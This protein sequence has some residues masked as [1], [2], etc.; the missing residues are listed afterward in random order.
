MLIFKPTLC[1]LLFAMMLTR[2]GKAQ[3]TFDCY[4]CMERTQYEIKAIVHGTSDDPTWQRMHAAMRQAAQDM[5]VEFGMSFA[6]DD[7]KDTTGVYAKM[8]EQIRSLASAAHALVVTIPDDTVKAAVEEVIAGGTPVFG[9]QSGYE[10]AMPAGVSAFVGMD[11]TLAGKEA[12]KHFDQKA[13][14]VISRALF[15]RSGDDDAESTAFDRR[16]Q[17]FVTGMKNG[18]ETSGASVQDLTWTKSA[19]SLSSLK[20]CSFDAVLLGTDS[21]DLMMQTFTALESCLNTKVGIFGTSVEIHQAVSG[22]KLAFAISSQD[23]YQG[24]MSIVHAALYVS[25]GK[26]LSPSSESEY[27]MILSGPEVMTSSNAYTDTF[28]VCE[29]D[30]FP[31]CPYELALDGTTPSQCACT[32]RKK[33]KIAGVLHAV[34]T[35]AFWD[36]VYTAANQAADDFGVELELDRM[37]PDTADVLHFKMAAQIETLCEQGVDGIFVTSTYTTRWPL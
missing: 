16:F 35:D 4:P 26:A 13:Q 21:L 18:N 22:G 14:N 31:V 23:Y 5:R 2:F 17:G 12:A 3:V 1:H 6:G 24:A 20:D 9:V 10:V 7:E 11:D 30:G 25:T 29:A 28:Q 36:I 15:V 37:E 32:D 19:S 34:T 33:L 8:A 27:G